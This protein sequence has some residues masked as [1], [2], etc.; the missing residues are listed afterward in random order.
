MKCSG[1][2]NSR[3]V[4]CACV[5]VSEWVLIR[6][7]VTGQKHTV[8]QYYIRVSVYGK[9]NKQTIHKWNKI[10]GEHFF[11]D[12]HAT[13]TL[14]DIFIFQFSFV[15]RLV[16]NN[17][18][19]KSGIRKTSCMRLV[20]WLT[21]FDNLVSPFFLFSFIISQSKSSTPYIVSSLMWGCNRCTKSKV[22]TYTFM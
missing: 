1:K 4:V 6:K 8:E 16:S 18:R 5:C 15:F 12:W 2:S 3:S 10:R 22:R 17:K 11:F 13:G 9:T 7:K 14:E 19:T 21:W 20:C